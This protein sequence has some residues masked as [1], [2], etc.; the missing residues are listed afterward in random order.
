MHLLLGNFSWAITNFHF[1]V[2]GKLFWGDTLRYIDKTD[3]FATISASWFSKK[4]FVRLCSL[5]GKKFFG[6]K[7]FVSRFVVKILGDFKITST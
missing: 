2:L 3:I 7:C 4:I 5:G 6:A 1:L